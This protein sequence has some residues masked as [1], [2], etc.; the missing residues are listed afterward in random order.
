MTHVKAATIDGCWAYLGTANF[1]PLS[2]RRNHELGL[3]VQACPLVAQVQAELF[4]P[5]FRPEWEMTR[6]LPCTSGDYVC[7]MFSSFC[8]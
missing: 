5:D 6:P 8:L 3:I 4:E 1:D 2:L 7:E